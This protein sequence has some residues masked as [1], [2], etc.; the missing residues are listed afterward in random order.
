MAC[1]NP[2]ADNSK[3]A[4]GKDAEANAIWLRQ[5]RKMLQRAAETGGRV[6]QVLSVS[7]GLSHMQHAE[8]DM[9]A[10]RHV[11]V[12]MIECG[13]S[14]AGTIEEQV[15]ASGL[16][17]ARVVQDEMQRLREEN[18]RQAEEIERLQALLRETERATL[19]SVSTQLETL[20][21]Q[22][23]HDSKRREV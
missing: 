23:E 7:E 21:A 19:M 15:R 20:S 4:A 11:P 8:A 14:G 22:L 2:N 3:L 16:D 13:E 18:R 9:A 1:F 6:V 12:V 10:D 17:V 5:W